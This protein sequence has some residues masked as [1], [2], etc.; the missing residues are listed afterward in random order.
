MRSDSQDD[1]PGL[2]S[3]AMKTEN[4]TYKEVNCTEQHKRPLDVVVAKAGLL[5]ELPIREDGDGVNYGGEGREA[6]RHKAAGP[7]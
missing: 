4:K 3:N 2:N 1:V 7:K 5:I 6:G